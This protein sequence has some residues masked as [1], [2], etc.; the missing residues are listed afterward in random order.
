MDFKAFVANV[1]DP[2]WE[3]VIT[4]LCGFRKNADEIIEHVAGLEKPEYMEDDLFRFRRGKNLGLYVRAGYQSKNEMKKIALLQSLEDFDFCF[5]SDTLA[6]RIRKIIKR[7]P[8][9][10]SI[11]IALQLI[12]A[13]AYY[14][15]L[16]QKAVFDSV[17]EVDERKLSY[18]LKLIADYKD[19][20]VFAV[21]V[22]RVNSKNQI[23]IKRACTIVCEEFAKDDDIKLLE[24]KEFRKLRKSAG[25]VLKGFKKKTH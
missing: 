14:S 2:W 16:T 7:K 17:N 15:K 23:E 3:N 6:E 4:F 12:L 18:M 22:D 20:D 13:H 25:M 8:G 11:H 9:K 19:K 5:E 21:A 10:K 24:S 1:S